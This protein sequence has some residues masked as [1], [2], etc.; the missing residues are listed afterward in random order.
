MPYI[1]RLNSEPEGTSL[2]LD[3]EESWAPIVSYDGSDVVE[4]IPVRLTADTDNA[5]AANLQTLHRIQE[6]VRY[7]VNEPSSQY[8]QET[9]LEWQMLD[10]STTVGPRRR[11]VKAMDVAFDKGMWFTCGDGNLAHEM[12]VVL[13][14]RCAGW[15]EATTSQTSVDTILTSTVMDT[16]V[17][18]G[19][20]DLLGDAPAR[21]DYLRIYER[22]GAGINHIYGAYVGFRSS[23][24]HGAL[25]NFVPIW[26][27][28]ASSTFDAD[29]SATIQAG[30]SPS[31]AVNNNA[32]TTFATNATF[33]TR[34]V[35]Q[36]QNVTANFSDNYGRYIVLYRGQVDAATSCTVRVDF[37]GV[38]NASSTAPTVMQGTAFT[39][40]NNTTWRMFETGL[41]VQLPP[42][43]THTTIAIPE[44]YGFKVVAS[45]DSGVGHLYS[46]C[47]VLIPI[48]EY[49]LFYRFDATGK[50]VSPPI[51]DYV[52]TYFYTSPDNINSVIIWS[53]PTEYVYVLD[54]PYTE[55]D[56][57]P[58]GDATWAYFLIYNTGT[59]DNVLT[60][61]ASVAFNYYP[62]YHS[63]Q[64]A[65]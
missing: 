24:R 48:D 28:E 20:G 8:T 33:I 53:S 55:G 26:E 34:A 43:G 14:L 2:T 59:G 10:E 52:R 36:F 47:L 9:W 7:Y 35:I 31:D 60:D 62:R 18:P 4:T 27:L 23:K 46:D 45:Q 16:I 41:I 44:Q 13:T 25:A 61:N 37:V 1:F 6:N 3:A 64:G 42:T 49:M 15:W 50:T 30:A 39:I 38:T 40:A 56:G 11:L 29:T 22:I 58:P 63:V 54:I 51:G 12:R 21:L 19:V 57:P 32:E 65:G 5:Q 17:L